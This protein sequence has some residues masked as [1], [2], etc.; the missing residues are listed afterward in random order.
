MTYFVP[1][2]SSMELFKDDCLVLRTP[3]KD[4]TFNYVLDTQFTEE[5]ARE[6]I[7]F[8][9]GLY[10]EKELPFSWWVGP[11]DA[12]TNLKDILLSCGFLPKEYDYGMY[13]PL[14]EFRITKLS[15]ID[16]ER[17]VDTRGLRDFFSIY[18]QSGGS[19]DV[20]D[21]IFSHLSSESYDE[22]MPYGFYVGYRG[23]TPVV[24][25]VSVISEQVAGIYYIITTPEER[26]KGYAT[27]MMEHLLL[28]ANADECHTAVLQ[29]SEAGRHVYAKMGF[30]ECGKFQEFCPKEYFSS[31]PGF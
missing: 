30:R 20:F 17:V 11:E 19:K 23:K 8:I 18:E 9:R 3:I 22:G 12:P 7:E 29:A 24:T 1:Y 15:T 28:F 25:G 16:I 5:N 10:K 2:V 14:E 26:R 31:T 21:S 6:K 13:L 4:D 27:E